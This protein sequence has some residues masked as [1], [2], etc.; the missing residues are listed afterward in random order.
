MCYN[1]QV[2]ATCTNRVHKILEKFDFV[3]KL[4]TPLGSATVY[5]K[6]TKVYDLQ[7]FKLKAPMG[8]NKE[9]FMKQQLQ[10]QMNIIE[11]KKRL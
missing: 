1:L 6:P 9:L 3:P 5:P 10:E 2:G 7:Y 4:P 8:N 11:R